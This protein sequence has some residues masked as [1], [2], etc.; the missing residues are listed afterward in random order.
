[1]NKEANCAG[2]P[3]ELVGA[4]EEME[5]AERMETGAETLQNTWQR[6]WPGSEGQRQ[7]MPLTPPVFLVGPA[8]HQRVSGLCDQ[9]LAS[10]IT[11]SAANPMC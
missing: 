10:H 1:M 2:F 6:H 9:A 4:E 8:A 7:S 5:T 11:E 3:E